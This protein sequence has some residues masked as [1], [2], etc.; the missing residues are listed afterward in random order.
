MEKGR[1]PDAGVESAHVKPSKERKQ[2]YK[3]HNRAQSR[4]FD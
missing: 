1:G 3:V 2:V 4:A